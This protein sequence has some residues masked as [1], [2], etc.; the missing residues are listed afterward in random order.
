[1]KCAVVY[2][3]YDGHTA[4]AA[5]QIKKQL[6]CDT[7]RLRLEGERHYRGFMKYIFYVLGKLYAKPAALSAYSFDVSQ[8][9][10]VI[11][12]F[13]IWAEKPV[14]AMSLFLAQNDLSG[15]KVALF[16]TSMSAREVYIKRCKSLVKQGSIIGAFNLREKEIGQERFRQWVGTLRW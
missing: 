4:K 1:M 2:Y 14:I 12:G 5:R 10:F 8:Y 6:S 11:L 3:S 7:L 15:K 13:P 16:C 9:D